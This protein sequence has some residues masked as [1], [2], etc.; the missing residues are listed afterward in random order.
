MQALD[1]SKQ[2]TQNFVKSVGD[3]L[4]MEIQTKVASL[5]E[6]IDSEGR[7]MYKKMQEDLQVLH[8]PR[9]LCEEMIALVQQSKTA[10]GFLK[11]EAGLRAR[12]EK[13]EK[14]PQLKPHYVSHGK[15]VEKLLSGVDVK[16]QKGKEKTLVQRASKT[17]KHWKSDVKGFDATAYRNLDVML[18][19][20]YVE[21]R[22]EEEDS[23]AVS[24]DFD[25]TDDDEEHSKQAWV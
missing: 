13:L 1:A 2:F 22:P 14:C 8:E 7:T 3:S 20:L 15:Y 17:L 12:A 25:S 18:K 23:D 19:N 11:K 24:W 10:H 9:K 4:V 16:S 21:S 5:M 6:R